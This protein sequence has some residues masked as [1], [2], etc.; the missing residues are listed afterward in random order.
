[1]GSAESKPS[2]SAEISSARVWTDICALTSDSTRAHMIETVLHAPDFV[3]CARRAGVYGNL[4]SWLVA[5]RRGE[6]VRFPYATG[7][8]PVASQPLPLWDRP[9][10]GSASTE[11]IVSPAAKAMDHF[12]ECLYLLGI[13]ESEPLTH[14]RIRSAYKRLA[15]RA[16]PD[17]GGSKE[18]FD[19]LR[20]AFQ[21]LE[22]IVDRVAP[23]AS[24]EEK[25]RLSAPVTMENA[26][27]MRSSTAPAAPVALSAKKLDMTT[28]NRLFEENR[29]PDPT[30]D[31]GYGDWLKAQE[32]SDEAVKDSRL[33]GKFNLN[34]F[35]KVFR[36]KALAQNKSTAITVRT[37]PSEL[38][39]MGGTELGASAD[40][41]SASMFSDTQFTDLKQAYTTGSTVFHEVA[42]VRVSERSASSIA[43]AKR[44]REAAMANVSPDENARIAAYAAEMEKRERERKLR[45]AQ[46]DT[47][48][49]QWSAHMRSR[50]FVKNG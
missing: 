41:F 18:K 20:R 29:L 3:A 9:H 35:E 50:L 14:E 34:T 8:T 48:A 47:Q 11:M 33:E 30:A 16:H 2:E 45:L 43:E 39:A 6:N 1:M 17:K 37:A 42:D 49:E 40:N 24:A 4:L 21:Y 28:F 44:Q 7:S 27:A 36:E 26:M 5:Y 15:V 12:Q 10:G 25:A 22:K 19:E 32:G 46:Q 23:R 38:I 31:T 13:E